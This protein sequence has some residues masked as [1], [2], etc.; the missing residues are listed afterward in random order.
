MG[1]LEMFDLR[2]T[3]EHR[4]KANQSNISRMFPILVVYN[5][6]TTKLKLT[7]MIMKLNINEEKVAI[8]VFFIFVQ[9]QE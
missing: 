5:Y 7:E 2:W 6:P 1:V 4:F 8:F 3:S 9:N